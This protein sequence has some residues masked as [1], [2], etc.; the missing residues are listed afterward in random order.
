MGIRVQSQTTVSQL[1]MAD[2]EIIRFEMAGMHWWSFGPLDSEFY[3][4]ERA[5]QVDSMMPAAA[6]LPLIVV[7]PEVYDTLLL[8]NA[9]AEVLTVLGNLQRDNPQA[10]VSPEVRYLEAL[11]LD[12][13]ADR[14]R[15]RQAYFT[16]WQRAA[17]SN[18][19]QLAAAH[20]EQR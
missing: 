10:A 15:A 5:E 16:L 6:P 20:L 11:S 8:A 3:L 1:G 14:S 17:Q 4:A 2:R 7:P 9:P 13:L 12:L 18:W 19:G